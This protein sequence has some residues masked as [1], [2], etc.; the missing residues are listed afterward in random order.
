MKTL[1]KDNLIKSLKENSFINKDSI[2]KEIDNINFKFMKKLYVNS[3][4]DKEIDIN[5]ISSCN[6]ISKIDLELEREYTNIGKEVLLNNEYGI[7]IMAGGNASRLGLNIPKGLL[8]INYKGKRISIFEIYI[9]KL[10]DM[11]NDINKYINIYIM[12]NSGAYKEVEEYFINNNYFD[13]PKDKIKLFIQDNLPLLSTTGNFLLKNK[14]SIWF[15]PSGN[16]NV[17]K[18]LK[19]NNLI[20]DMVHNNIKYCLF[21]GID[22]LLVNLVDYKFIGCTL[23]NNYK[24][25]SKSIYKTNKDE[26][27]WVFCKYKNK[28]FMLD[29]RYVCEFTNKVNSNN[30]F[31]YREKNI[32][33]HLIHIDY[34][35]KFANVTLPYHRAYKEYEVFNKFGEFEKVKCFKFEKFIYDAFTYANDMLIYRVSDDEFCPLKRYEDIAKVENI[36]NKKYKDF[37]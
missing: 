35:K 20:K 6:I 17:F 28:P 14:K 27:D 32:I 18:S 36:L 2:L 16:G 4:R 34:I 12:L 10:K 9:N 29:D 19:K 3:Y 37:E 13:Y 11:Y 25:A 24:L 5:K 23:K 26:L 33:Y 7:V 1:E 15:A 30:E 21:I 8:K 31:C 22:N